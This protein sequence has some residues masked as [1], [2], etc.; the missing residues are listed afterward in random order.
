MIAAA[1]PSSP[2]VAI[3]GMG[4]TGCS[5]ARFL[6]KSGVAY[7]AFDEK[8]KSLPEQIKGPLKSGGLQARALKK[9]SRLVVSPGI[10]WRHPALQAARK[11]GVELLGDLDLFGEHF[12]GEIMA[13]TGTNGKST[14][15]HLMGQ[16]LEVLS[17]GVEIGGNIG[18]PMLDMLEH[19]SLSPRAVLELSSFQLE[20]CHGIHP[21]WAALLN[22]QPDHADMHADMTQ[23]EAAKLRLFEQQADGDIAMLPQ[24]GHWN[25]LAWKLGEKGVYV[26]RFGLVD[27][28]AQ[29][30]AGLTGAA[31]T[32][33]IFWHRRES[34]Y[35]LAV[36]QIR[37]RGEHQYI[38]LAVAAQAATDAGVSSGVIV[39][40][41]TAFQGLDHR[42]RYVG[43]RAARPWYDDS[44]AT[45]PDA[46]VAALN[47]F[48]QVIWV[49]G[50]LTK[51][52]DL[53]SM[54]PAVQ[55]HVALAL[56][57]G[58][59]AKPF[60]G[61]LEKAGVP[62]QVMRNID[63]A[64]AQAARNNMHLPVLLS[65][66]AASQDQFRDYAKRGENFCAAVASLVKT[67]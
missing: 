60:A 45:N 52:V 31:G 22:I 35:K 55:K 67:A 6:E 32:R 66:A 43:E 56:V 38:N 2:D 62:Y 20:R 63:E 37:V 54:L 25:D 65:P 10:P 4:C 18:L 12:G 16:M 24:D 3:I 57:I 11:S 8:L 29:A 53:Q 26:R 1:R 48:E 50:G 59:D 34:V 15:V 19:S 17:G 21:R 33:H 13:V 30:D 42:L 61:L 46:A 5:V 36:S 44:K 9:F 49:C 14:V 39:E 40:S 27:D 7:V 58:V 28:C 23:Y 64:V 51:G 41:L 47:S